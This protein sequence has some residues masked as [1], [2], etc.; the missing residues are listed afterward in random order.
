ML[1]GACGEYS[2]RYIARVS[3]WLAALIAWVHR[4]FGRRPRLLASAPR[5]G[6]WDPRARDLDAEL[7]GQ[8]SGLERESGVVRDTV[9]R[10]VVDYCDLR[11]LIGGPG[12]FD[13]IGDLDLLGEAEAALRDLVARAPGVSVV[14]GVARDRTDR[15]EREA[16]G[17]ALLGFCDRGRALAVVTSAA[18]RWSAS[19]NA[20][21]REQLES[22]L[23][24]LRQP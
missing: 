22:A 11:D 16:A 15:G 23:A 9:T 14:V 12:S 4:L 6:A 5:S 2:P 20:V 17:D 7:R 8:L 3:R 24:R 18:L 13:V 1:P 19:R 21:D 10:A